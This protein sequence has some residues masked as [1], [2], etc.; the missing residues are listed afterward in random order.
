MYHFYYFL[1]TLAR[2]TARIESTSPSSSVL[3]EVQVPNTHVGATRTLCVQG[4][5]PLTSTSW[6]KADLRIPAVSVSHTGCLT[7]G[8][9]VETNLNLSLGASPNEPR[10]SAFQVFADCSGNFVSLLVIKNVTFGDGGNYVFSP[11]VG[12]VLNTATFVVAEPGK[13]KTQNVSISCVSHISF[14]FFEHLVLCVRERYLAEYTLVKFSAWL[15][16]LNLLHRQIGFSKPSYAWV[17]V[18]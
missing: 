14:G 5:S 16:R 10:Y 7:C 9:L 13:S 6:M 3:G 18:V 11:L 1:H 17:R 15:C 4:E 8:C 2:P 12:G